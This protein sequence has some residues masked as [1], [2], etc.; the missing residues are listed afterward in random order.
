MAETIAYRKKEFKKGIDT[1]DLRRERGDEAYQIRKQKREEILSKRRHHVQTPQNSSD[2]QKNKYWNENIQNVYSNVPNVVMEALS[3]IR[4]QM[5]FP[6]PPI[7]ELIKANVIPK[8]IEILSYTEYP[9]HQKEAAWILTNA[10]SGASEQTRYILDNTLLIDYIGKCFQLPNRS[11]KEEC[12]WC[13]ANI[14]GEGREYRDALINNGTYDVVLYSFM[15]EL[16][17]E[18]GSI[19]FIKNYTWCLSNFMKYKPVSSDVCFK[20]LPV[21]NRVIRNVCGEEI[22]NDAMWSLSYITTT[23]RNNELN[24]FS[25]F[26][27]FDQNIFRFLKDS[28]LATPLIRTCGNLIAG[29]DETTQFLL[30]LGFLTYLPTLLQNKVSLRKEICWIISNITAGTVQQIQSVLDSGLVE[31]VIEYLKNERWEIKRECAYV[32]YNII[33]GNDIKQI[34][35]VISL[36]CMKPFC[37]LLFCSDVKIIKLVLKCIHNMLDLDGKYS[38]LIEEYA[39]DSIEAL[40]YNSSEEV[41]ESCVNIIEKF[42][43]DETFDMEIEPNTVFNF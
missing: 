5:S 20:A 10:V 2:E 6:N 36:G 26:G 28:K 40:Q 12:I 9:S 3:F 14:A 17:Y 31:T 37:D 11:L 4:K 18:K 19:E 16:S 33:M 35:H 27:I 25:K 43:Y 32:I 24:S 23:L 42:F 41:Y 22:L 38:N 13:I 8:I 7:R 34:D 29:P 21:L 30:D 1:D 15:Y 39:L